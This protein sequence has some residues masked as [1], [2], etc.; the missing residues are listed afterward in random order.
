MNTY[1]QLALSNN[2]SLYFAA[3]TTTDQSGTSTYALSSNTL[4]AA[5]QPIIYGSDSSFLVDSS[6]K[7][8]I[9]GNPIFVNS[10]V[11]MELMGVFRQPTDDVNILIDS[12]G[13]NALTVGPNGFT[14][15]VYFQNSLL[16]YTKSAAVNIKQW[17][18][19]F[20]IQLLFSGTRAAISVNG[21]LDEI[22]FDTP[23]TESTA[24][25]LGGGYS[26]YS[27]LLDGIGFYNKSITDKTKF[28]NDPG[29]GYDRYSGIV[30]SGNT[31]V[32]DGFKRGYTTKYAATDF[33][34]VSNPDYFILTHMASFAEQDPGYLIVRCNDETVQINCTIDNAAMI[35]FTGYALI[36]ITTNSIL[37][38]Q[39]PKSNFN[40]NLTITIEAV[41]SGNVADKTPAKLALTGKALYPLNFDNSI[42][43]YPLGVQ[44]LHSTYTG[45]WL[46]GPTSPNIPKSIELVFKPLDSTVKT[47]VLN[48]GDGECSFGPGGQITNFTAYLNGSVVTNLTNIKMNQWNHLILTLASPT[49]TTFYLNSAAGSIPA[50]DLTYMLLGS[51]QQVLSLQNVTALFS[52]LS[53]VDKISVTEPSIPIAEHIFD[54]GFGFNYYSFP[55]SI[56]GAGGR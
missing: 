55:W 52:V 10:N 19:K 18:I 16:T 12:S 23:M 49:A 29:T 14:L 38:I 31:S 37:H 24:V 40:S 35:T 17:D 41:Y 2:P 15:K 28:I 43:N 22:S 48:N 20:H 42:V 50:T 7:V 34:F 6:H 32:L 39:I 27:F 30:F 33:K 51:Y 9:N 13:Q 36:D 44:L 5:G 45:T 54:N 21:E 56:V 26:G 1:T 46:Y 47:Y 8:N 53:G 3:P 4:S 25:T 11:V